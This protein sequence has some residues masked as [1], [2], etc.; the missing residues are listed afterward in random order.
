MTGIP[1]NY[2]ERKRM[3]ISKM[4]IKDADYKH[5]KIL[6]LDDMLSSNNNSSDGW[7]NLK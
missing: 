3:E 5:K 4:T 1:E 6:E 2:D 7:K